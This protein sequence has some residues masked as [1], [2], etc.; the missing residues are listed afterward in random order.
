M[1][2]PFGDDGAGDAV[3][4]LHGS[5]GT[6]LHWLQVTPELVARWRVLA[7]DFVD[8]GRALEVDDLVGQ[9]VSVLDAAGVDRAHVA[10]WSLGAAAAAALAAAHPERVRSLALV[11]GWARSDPSLAFMFDGWRR[12]LDTDPELY[13]RVVLPDI[14]TPGWFALVGDAA[15]GV[16]RMSAAAISPASAGH[17]ELDGRLDIGDRL[18]SIV[19]PTLVV[20]GRHDRV[21][22]VEHGR[23][24]AAAI[25]GA[26]LVELD[27]GHGLT[28]EGAAELAPLLAGWFARH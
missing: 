22:P 27:L 4:L 9:A 13:M 26:E 14:F 10:G 28:T 25:A 7:P 19:A 8:P 17:A 18:A 3:L 6:R 15:E 24:L 16:A 5:T 20:H 1:L 12:L 21:L 23:A 11:S 2:V